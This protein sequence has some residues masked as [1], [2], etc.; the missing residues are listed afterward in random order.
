MARGA[1]PPGETRPTR[2]PP[3]AVGLSLR[4]SVDA[5]ATRLSDAGAR[6]ELHGLVANERG[7]PV[8]ATYGAAL[9]ACCFLAL[10]WPLRASVL[11][12]VLLVSGLLDLEGRRSWLRQLAPREG[13]R[14][15]LQ[16]PTA[17]APPGPLV[18]LVV[19]D[20][21]TR[22][23]APGFVASAL[24]ALGLLSLAG[25]LA[26]PFLT[27]LTTPLL[28]TMGTAGL[29]IT[30]LAWL[31]DRRGR[32]AP[33][34][35]SGVRLAER[36]V[37][38]LERQPPARGR[39]AVATIGGGTLFHDGVGVVLQNHRARLPTETT[40]VVTWQPADG[41]LSLVPRDG[42]LLRSR[43]DPALLAA[44]EPLGLPASGGVT[45]AARARACGWRA[46]GLQG[47]LDDPGSIVKALADAARRAIESE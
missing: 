33:D 46:V 6:V 45:A 39:V 5:A 43:P 47:G 15:L 10:A 23:R 25:A 13:G 37:A 29:I 24:G 11:L 21:A 19:P 20:E 1:H 8:A 4:Q 18:L 16:W 34:G 17:P 30:A 32:P 2:Q 7:G 22:S 14:A 9:A 42:R 31:L 28:A 12:G 27:D 35:E 26:R 44:L 40:R 38:A 36:I 41:A 3:E